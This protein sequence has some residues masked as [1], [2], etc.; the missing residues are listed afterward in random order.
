MMQDNISKYSS[1]KQQAEELA[2]NVAT[3]ISEAIHSNGRAILAVAGG[4]T[5]ALFF[6]HLS[7]ADLDW[8]KVVITTT[9]ERFVSRNSPRSNARLVSETLLINHAA[10]AEFVALC[11]GES[12]SKAAAQ[13]AASKIEGL[14][15]LDVCVLGMGADMHIA[16]LFPDTPGLEEAISSVCP[17]LVLPM[18]PPTADEERLTLTL[19]VLMGAKNLHIL[20]VGSDKLEALNQSETIDTVIKAPVKSILSH[21]A[22]AIHYAEKAV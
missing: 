17:D 15:P 7:R 4:T 3:Q 16:S 14:L 6:D 1:P 9:D 12:T 21:K 10:S 5:P 22:L 11:D 8:S 2:R 13:D 19:P 20:I 18:K